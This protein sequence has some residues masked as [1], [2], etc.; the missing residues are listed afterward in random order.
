MS[1]EMKAQVDAL[2]AELVPTSLSAIQDQ[3]M[4]PL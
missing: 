3:N 1:D 4:L 2:L